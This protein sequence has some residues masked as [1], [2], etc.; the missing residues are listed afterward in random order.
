MNTK[1][2]LWILQVLDPTSGEV[3]KEIEAESVRK[4]ADKCNGYLTFGEIH[5]LHR[6]QIKSKQ[7][8]RLL[9]VQP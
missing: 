4:L 8:L 6:I 7:T 1:R 5:S 3:L 9:K 2:A